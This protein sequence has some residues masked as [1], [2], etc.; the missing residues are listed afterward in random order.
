MTKRG[1]IILIVFLSLICLL[2]TGGFIY[3]LTSDF[4]WG[5]FNLSFSSSKLI[6]SITYSNDCEVLHID[7]KN[8]D[9]FVE[10]AVDNQITLEVYANKNIDYSFNNNDKKIEFK[11]HNNKTINLFNFGQSKIVVKLPKENS[12]SDFLIDAKVGDIKVDSFESLN[13]KIINTV[14]DL[15]IEKFNDLYIEL[16]TG[17]IKINQVNSLEIKHSTGDIDVDTVESFKC[18]STTGDISINDINSR[19]EITSKTGDIRIDKAL[20]NDNSL[21]KH[22]TG[23]VKIKEVKNAYVDATTKVGDV[24]VNNNDRYAEY[25]LTINNKTGDIKIN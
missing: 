10:E 17:D 12:I 25:T 4:S 21:I 6:D 5:S 7:S 16:G 15:D 9:V 13:G 3:L 11:A 23:D 8:I 2:M 18:E 1:I 22:T 24:K 19:F 14:G 20:L